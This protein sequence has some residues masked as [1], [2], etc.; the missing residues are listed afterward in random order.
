[1]TGERPNEQPLHL[2]VSN[3]SLAVDPVAVEVDL[4]GRQIF[5]RE[6][7]TGTQ[8]NWERAEI[9][10]PVGKYTLTV[11]E[12]KTQTRQ[13]QELN[14]SGELWVVIRFLGPPAQLKVDVFDH[15]VGLM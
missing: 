3:Q 4:D 1:M 6:L 9:S 15:P 14:V 11:S 7:S 5:Q 10:A 13:S 12:A 8:H 2:F